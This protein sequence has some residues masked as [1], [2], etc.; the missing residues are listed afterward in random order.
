[1]FMCVGVCLSIS[2]VVV[3]VYGVMCVGNVAFSFLLFSF[4]SSLSKQKT[5]KT[6]F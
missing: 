2:I 3:V 5:K 1:M 4:F 6:T